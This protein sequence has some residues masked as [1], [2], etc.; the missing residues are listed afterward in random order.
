MPA[1]G[2]ATCSWLPDLHPDD[3]SL[4]AALEDG[5]V[6]AV[7]A[8]WTDPD[9]D[10]AAFD[11]VV[12]RTTWDYFDR[13]DEFVAWAERVER[14][15]PLWNPAGTIRWNSEKSYLRDLAARGVPVVPT[16]WVD[17]GPLAGVLDEHGWDDAVVKPVVGVGSR[18]LL[19]V[20]PGE[21]EDHLE[22][23]LRAGPA[24]VQPFLP[25]IADG[26]LSVV[27]VNGEPSHA[28]RKRPKRGDIRSQPEYGATA[29]PV[30]IGPEAAAAVAAVLAAVEHPALYARVDLLEG[31]DGELLLMELEAVEPRLFLEDV[32]GAGERI[33]AAILAL[34]PA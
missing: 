10:W 21:G 11:V 26:E 9:V 27:C 5:G 20:A 23:L 18:G 14:I 32:P 33:A 25:A 17:S 30:E 24:L 28:V 8:V 15:V 34:L 7:P 3:R 29:E 2:L 1:V 22:Q 4:A 12:V 16:A 19:R 6:A 13:R 31:E